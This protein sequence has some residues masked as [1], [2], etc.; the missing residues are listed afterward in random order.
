M[1]TVIL[2]HRVKDYA[3]WRPLF[4]SDRARRDGA[5]IKEIA[6]GEKVGDPGNVY[7]IWEMADPSVITKMMADPELQKTMEAGGVI[8]IPEV[9]VIG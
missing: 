3:T 6:V 7:M 9:I 8:S 4:D 2:N 1:A 5:G